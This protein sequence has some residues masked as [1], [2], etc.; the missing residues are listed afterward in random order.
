[1][2]ISNDRVIILRVTQRARALIT[3]INLITIAYIVARLMIHDTVNQYEY[4]DVN[5]ATYL[6]VTRDE[7][8]SGYVHAQL[9][10]M[11]DAALLSNR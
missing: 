11:A 7:S 10:T 9:I 6:R 5:P 2:K 3:L 4:L 1:M 8:T